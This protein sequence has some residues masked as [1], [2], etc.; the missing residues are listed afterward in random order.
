MQWLFKVP[1]FSAGFV[2]IDASIA[3]KNYLE[4]LLLFQPLQVTKHCLVKSAFLHTDT[5]MMSS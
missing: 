5:E 4:E 2:I 1:V 3:N